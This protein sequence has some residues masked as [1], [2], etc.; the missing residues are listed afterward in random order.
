M[1]SVNSIFFDEDNIKE[2]SNQ[3]QKNFQQESSFELQ[4]ESEESM[5]QLI[6]LNK[7]QQ[8]VDTRRQGEMQ[9]K[10][11]KFVKNSKKR[12]LVKQKKQESEDEQM[13]EL[14]IV[15][16]N[17]ENPKKTDIISKSNLSS[18]KDENQQQNNIYSQQDKSKQLVKNTQLDLEIQMTD[19]K[20]KPLQ[21][22]QP[23]SQK[24]RS[25]G[26]QVYENYTC[27]LNLTDIS[28]GV[29]GHNKFYQ[30]EVLHMKFSKFTVYTKW[31]RVGAQNPQET[32]KGYEN[33]YDAILAFKKKFYEK[34][35]N[36]WNGDFS[37]FKVQPGKYTWIQV[38]GESSKSSINQD[39]E[40]LNQRNEL[41][42]KKIQELPSQLEQKIKSLM[43]IIWDFSRISK[44]LKELNFDTEK[45]PLGKLS[46]QQIQKGYKI[47]TEIQNAIIQNA[48]KSIIIELTNQ[49]YTNIPQNYG[50]KQLP[51]ID[52][53]QKV[54]EKIYLLDI[55]KEVDITNK[56][57]NQALQSKVKNYLINYCFYQM[58]KAKIEILN[59]QDIQYKIIQ[60]M[61]Q[62]TH[63]PSHNKY[64]LSIKD[65]YL[66]D[67]KSEKQRFFPFTQL[68]NKKYRIMQVFQ[69]KDQEQLLQRL[70]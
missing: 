23:K 8:S 16:E 28:Y 41:L 58:L 70:L 68:G 64:K 9:K 52:H 67:K 59:P 24:Q 35:H 27:M 49:F 32:Y 1:S 63:G 19:L 37:S 45:N 42:K 20:I 38:E 22:T 50:M 33:K 66:V 43:L 31:G 21:A 62:N 69:V 25:D 7:T 26:Y 61:I 47:L 5:K 44:T 36:D 51:I 55:L 14:E 2:D 39:V 3:N 6:Q 65:I 34:T 18:R 10:L 56:Y 57:I 17:E 54:R 4:Q 30:I 60:K 29:K 48:K 53:I 15:S 13:I 11:M 40:K 46:Y 12:K